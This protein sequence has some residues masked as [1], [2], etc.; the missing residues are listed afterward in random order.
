MDKS[1]WLPS[2]LLG[3]LLLVVVA[4]GSVLAYTKELPWSDRFEVHA[5]FTSAQTIR[6]SSPVRIA[7]VNVGEVTD[8]ELTGEP[9]EDETG[10]L[11]PRSG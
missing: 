11:R 8:V 5:V 9:V 2:W 4:V 10:N 7:G 1:R 6:T 3:L